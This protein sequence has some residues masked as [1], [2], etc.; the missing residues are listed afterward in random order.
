MLLPPRLD[1]MLHH[2]WFGKIPVGNILASLHEDNADFGF[3]SCVVHSG[4]CLW[5]NWFYIMGNPAQLGSGFWCWI[6]EGWVTSSS[7]VQNKVVVLTFELNLH[8]EYRFIASCN[9]LLMKYFVRRCLLWWDKVGLIKTIQLCPR[10][11][12]PW[13]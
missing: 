9:E 7:F 2:K 11:Y 3:E 6:V 8:Y 10:F 12:I 13:C 1:Y 4:L 5:V